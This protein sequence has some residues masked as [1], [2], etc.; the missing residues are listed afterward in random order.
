MFQ[1]LVLKI[2]EKAFKYGSEELVLL[3]LL[4]A[5][6]LSPLLVAYHDIFPNG[7]LMKSFH[8]D[9]FV[10][11][12]KKLVSYVQ[13]VEDVSIIVSDLS[14]F[15]QAQKRSYKSWEYPV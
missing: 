11:S 8:I 15:L 4:K 2:F 1:N 3:L 12:I 10:S 13:Y 7:F 5:N 6:L 14:L 9:S